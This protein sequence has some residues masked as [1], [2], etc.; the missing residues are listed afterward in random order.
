MP[1]GRRPRSSTADYRVAVSRAR[2]DGADGVHGEGRRRS[3]RGLDR[4]AGSAERALRGGQGARHRRGATSTSPTSCSA[5]D[6][7]GGLPFTFDYVD[8]GVR[9]AKAMSPAPVKTDLDAAR[10]TSSTTTTAAPAMSRF[11]GALDANGTPLAVA[12]ELHRRRRRRGGVHAVRDRRA[13]RRSEKKAAHPIRLGAVAIGAELAARL[14]Q[15]IVHRRDGA[16]GRQGPVRVP[17]RSA[18]RLSRASRRRSNASAAHVG[19]GQRRCRPGEG[20]G[21]AICRVLRHRSSPKSRTSRCRPKGKLRVRNVYAAVDC[22]DVVNPDSATAQVGGRHHLRLVGRAAQRDHHRR[23][24]R[25][26]ARTS[27]TTR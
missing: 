8:L 3:R 12:L 15:G 4:R 17:A 7:D 24:P 23:R 1:Q 5:A 25:R 26:A 10:T 16:R 13:R 2:D 14:L 11:A 9:V 27:A 6:S 21:I 19:L 20:R 22:G 18:G